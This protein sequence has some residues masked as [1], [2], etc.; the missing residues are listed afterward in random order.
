VI[1]NGKVSAEE[2]KDGKLIAERIDSIE[3]V[4]KTLW[5]QYKDETE[6]SDKIN[7]IK[8]IL[9]EHPG[10]DGLRGYISDQK[11]VLHPD[12]GGTEISAQLVSELREVLGNDNVKVT[13]ALPQV[14]GWRR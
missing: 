13:Y 5:V 7:D 8:K 12:E 11:K 10:E 4:Q 3:S 1:I 2:E 6:R 9:S 14:K